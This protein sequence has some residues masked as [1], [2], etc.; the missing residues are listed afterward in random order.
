MPTGV[1]PGLGDEPPELPGDLAV[2][3]CDDDAHVSTVASA[4]Q[5]AC[6]GSR[7]RR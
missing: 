7:T 1:V 3:T 4:R 6:T 5:V 2:S